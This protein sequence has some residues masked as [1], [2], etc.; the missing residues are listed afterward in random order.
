MKNID[1]DNE[2]PKRGVRRVIKQVFVSEDGSEKSVTSQVI[3]DE[4]E[5][6]GTIVHGRDEFLLAHEEKNH[7]KRTGRII[8]IS[9]VFVGSIMLASFVGMLLAL[10]DSDKNFDDLKIAMFQNGEVV[11][12]TQDYD[13]KT[14]S[15]ID[16]EEDEIAEATVSSKEEIEKKLQ[17]I[18]NLKNID[19]QDGLVDDPMKVS[20]EVT[21]PKEALDIEGNL[22][23]EA[24]LNSE[25]ISD[26]EEASDSDG[27]TD[28]D[29]VSNKE[30]VVN[31]EKVVA[32]ETDSQLTNEISGVTSIAKAGSDDEIIN[33]GE[34]TIVVPYVDPTLNYPLSFTKVDESYFKDALFIGDSRLQGFGMWSNLPATYYC[35]V[36]FQ[37]YKY[38]TT[39]VVQTEAGKVPIFDA[40]PYNAF[41]KV[42]IKVGLNEMGWG[43]EEK[44]EAIYAEVIDKIRQM[45]P[46]AIIYIHGLLPVTAQKSAEG[47]S[48]NNTNIYERNEALKRFAVSQ[49][50]YF[51]D[52]GQAVANAEG[53]LPEEMANDGIHLKSQYIA[54]WK[55]YLLDNAI[56]LH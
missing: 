56:V 46:R 55:Q 54:L 26:S 40:M 8:A 34:E 50:A 5:V 19:S 13:D 28:G 45:Q 41:S 27:V 21:E 39:N 47:D 32:Q 44:F 10:W 53:C 3:K 30:E 14:A 17:E 35:A 49:K 51:I 23:T 52:A 1:K 29:D 24:T 48:H 11:A 25:Q 7:K 15:A 36:G 33:N 20:A 37:L 31:D 16:Y 9:A 12:S 6:H 22:N 42:Y 18:S 38:E 43:N 4:D 2:K